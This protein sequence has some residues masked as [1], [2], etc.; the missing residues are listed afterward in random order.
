[1]TGNSARAVACF[2]RLIG[3]PDAEQTL[4]DALTEQRHEIRSA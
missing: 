2:A 3:R 1:L 4:R